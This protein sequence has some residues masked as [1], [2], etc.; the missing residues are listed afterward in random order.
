ME[1]TTSE[2]IDGYL[3]VYE[4]IK[5]VVEDAVIVASVIEQIG[6]DKRCECLMNGRSNGNGNGYSNGNDDDL[7]TEK[8]V[9]FAVIGDGR[10]FVQADVPIVS[11]RQ[12]HADAEPRFDRGP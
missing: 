10:A 8:Q 7:A 3:E 12:D 4:R 6:K 1:K 2:R 11:S 5:P 9:G